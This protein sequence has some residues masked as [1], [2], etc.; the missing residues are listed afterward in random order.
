MLTIDHTWWICC[1]GWGGSVSS[2][3]HPRAWATEDLPLAYTSWWADGISMWTS[4][5]E[6][7]CL[8]RTVHCL[9]EVFWK[10]LLSRYLTLYQGRI[11]VELMSH[12]LLNYLS[13]LISLC[14]EDVIFGMLLQH[15][16]DDV[17][18]INA[19][20]NSICPFFIPLLKLLMKQIW[21]YSLYVHFHTPLLCSVWLVLNFI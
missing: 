19:F 15:W 10:L 18:N 3:P 16:T 17:H 9:L 20:C 11:I 4:F 1:P 21:F 8:T 7:S 2:T 13:I 5:Q 12:M 6:K 14:Y